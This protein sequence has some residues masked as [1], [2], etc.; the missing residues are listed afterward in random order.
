MV[1]KARPI[2][3]QGALLIQD[4]LERTELINPDVLSGPLKLESDLP[5]HEYD[6]ALVDPNPG[7]STPLVLGWTMLHRVLNDIARERS[8]TK[9]FLRWSEDSRP[10]RKFADQVDLEGDATLELVKGSGGKKYTKAQ[11]RI[12][13]FWR[14]QVKRARY[15]NALYGVTDDSTFD[16]FVP[17]EISSVEHRFF[18]DDPEE[19]KTK[20]KKRKIIAQFVK[21]HR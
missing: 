16:D 21:R 2:P 10:V 5:T 14:K 20:E 13:D 11:L 7:P 19:A 9:G 18:S 8:N 3:D 12:N 17:M 4:P 6:P 15:Y 1:R